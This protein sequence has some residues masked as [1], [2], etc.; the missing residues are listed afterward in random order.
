MKSIKIL[1]ILIFLF[2]IILSSGCKNRVSYN[3]TTWEEW[4]SQLLG[5]DLNKKYNSP[6]VTFDGDA[7]R[8]DFVKQ[9]NELIIKLIANRYLSGASQ[10]DEVVKDMVRLKLI[11][12]WREG[13]NI[14]LRNELLSEGYV[15]GIDEFEEWKLRFRDSINSAKNNEKMDDIQYCIFGT[16]NTHFANFILKGPKN[17]S[18][19]FPLDFT[20]KEHLKN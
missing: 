18:I 16:M 7:I 6:G 19:A 17:K 2:S 20:R 9:Y 14:I 4:C 3:V 11:G 10:D 15:Q 12:V 1:F 13:D 8:E 5:E